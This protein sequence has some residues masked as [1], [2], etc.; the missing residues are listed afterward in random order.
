MSNTQDLGHYIPQVRVGGVRLNSNEPL[1]VASTATFSGTVNFTGST[2]FTGGQVFT[3]TSANAL[4]VGPAG[5]T[6]PS[7]NVDA[8]AASAATGLNIAAAAAGSGVTLSTIS[9]ASS[10]SLT[11]QAKGSL[12]SMTFQ[13]TNGFSFNSATTIASGSTTALSVGRTGSTNPIFNVDDSTGSAVAGLNVKGAV[14][15][16]TVAVTTSDTGSNTSLTIAAKGTGTV[17]FNPAVTATA[18][19]ATNDGIRF[20]SL[21]V[22]LFTGTGAPTFSAMNGSIYV[23]SNATTTTTRIYVNNSGAGTAGT[24]WTNLTTAA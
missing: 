11:I 13:A 6:N 12:G 23:D 16:G 14:T 8:S 7:L 18:G 10:D 15:G 2:S 4:T 1:V 9:S 22:G 17:T 21:S 24:T 19:G 20:G 3:S 5:T